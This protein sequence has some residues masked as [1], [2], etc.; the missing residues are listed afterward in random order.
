MQRWHSQINQATCLQE[1]KLLCDTPEEM[2]DLAVLETKWLAL[3]TDAA[4]KNNIRLYLKTHINAK[5]LPLLSAIITLLSMPVHASQQLISQLNEALTKSKSECRTQIN[6]IAAHLFG[7]SSLQHQAIKLCFL[8]EQ[9]NICN[10]ELYKHLD[11]DNDEVDPVKVHYL[12]AQFFIAL[13]ELDPASK[14]TLFADFIKILPLSTTDFYKGLMKLMRFPA[15]L[16]IALAGACID[17]NN[18]KKFTAYFLKHFSHPSDDQIAA[19]EIAKKQLVTIIAHLRYT[20]RPE[21]IAKLLDEIELCAFGFYD[22]VEDASNELIKVNNLPELFALLLRQIIE[23]IFTEIE[24]PKPKD[25]GRSVHGHHQIFYLAQKAG[26]GVSAPTIPDRFSCTDGTEELTQLLIQGMQQRLTPENIIRTIWEKAAPF[27]HYGYGGKLD[28]GYQTGAIQKIFKFFKKIFNDDQFAVTDFFIVN[29]DTDLVSDINWYFVNSLLLKYLIKNQY[30]LAFNDPVEKTFVFNEHTLTL[31]HEKNDHLLD[32]ARITYRY[33][34]E[35]G[36]SCTDYCL[37]TMPEQV[38]G[39]MQKLPD[40]LKRDIENYALNTSENYQSA[41]AYY[42]LLPYSTLSHINHLA[43]KFAKELEKMDHSFL[44]MLNRLSLEKYQHCLVDAKFPIKRI[45]TNLPL[46]QSN[47]FPIEPKKR[48]ILL[49]RIKSVLSKNSELNLATLVLLLNQLTTDEQLDLI[50]S[51]LPKLS[52]ELMNATN[53]S[54]L[55]N[56]L[57]TSAFNQILLNTKELFAVRLV[58]MQFLRDLNDQTVEEENAKNNFSAFLTIQLDKIEPLIVNASDYGFI[59]SNIH[60]SKQDAFILSLENK[61]LQFFPDLNALKAI[62]GA[63]QPDNFAL[64]LELLQNKNS[65]LLAD[66]D[67]FIA[68]LKDVS[69]PQCRKICMANQARITPFLQKIVSFK[70]LV[71]LLDA[72]KMKMLIKQFPALIAEGV[73]NVDDFNVVITLADKNDKEIFYALVKIKLQIF[74][75]SN[76]G[77]DN[78]L[79]ALQPTFLE[80]LLSSVKFTLSLKEFINLWEKCPERNKN[81]FLKAMAS[82]LTALIANYNDLDALLST[83]DSD[84]LE[85]IY[86]EITPKMTEILGKDLSHFTKVLAKI[87]THLYVDFCKITNI[88]QSELLHNK[89]AFTKLMTLV[90]SPKIKLL[91]SA[92]NAKTF[93][94]LFPK[95][96]DF[97]DL[98]LSQKNTELR[99]KLLQAFLPKFVANITD[100]TQ[101]FYAVLNLTPEECTP[102]FT[103]IQNA[104]PSL[105]KDINQLSELLRVT[106]QDQQ[107]ILC[108]GLSQHICGIVLTSIDFNMVLVN[109]DIKLYAQL[110]QDL[111]PALPRLVS[112]P[113]KI[114]ALFKNLPDDKAHHLYFLLCLQGIIQSAKHAETIFSYCNQQQIQS[115]F[116]T[117]SIANVS[118]NQPVSTDQLVS[119]FHECFSLLNNNASWIPIFVRS[120]YSEELQEQ[121]LSPEDE[122]NEIRRHAQQKPNSRTAQALQLLFIKERNHPLTLAD[123]LSTFHNNYLTLRTTKKSQLTFF[124]QDKPLTVANPAD[125][126][127]KID[128]LTKTAPTSTNA[129]AWKLINS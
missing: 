18:K 87:P 57:Q 70:K 61:L 2:T 42:G 8:D 47:I 124:N 9:K 82:R 33:L 94:F 24:K 7:T 93:L 114:A 45:I 88:D 19:M 65:N 105:I 111:T 41:F 90:P 17:H 21:I 40:E 126:K 12:L 60:F 104:L 125:F 120:N 100:C 11:K 25:T 52:I 22:R 51:V 20:E 112:N 69:I 122:W 121:G 78:A 26:L 44:A 34:D 31:I 43:K 53:L 102:L 46:S 106:N 13:H 91:F 63:L 109:A 85:L 113:Q 15:I 127:P 35:N 67:E 84:Q 55:I 74:I 37:A 32:N 115:V 77:L 117:K 29:S 80:P 107:I 103:H 30:L 81:I 39:L 23:E 3:T 64:T 83:L 72:D 71:N 48:E 86:T 96:N 116:F 27:K 99:K 59:V 68:L 108:N 50:L 73:N 14:S 10:N 89:N 62:A 4:Q 119:A 118:S 75:Q 16:L 95:T 101:L 66:D 49:T 58:N 128:E 36:K 97:V 6:S 79:V 98:L 123:K 76:A 56:Q 54:F 129:V 38:S 110:L 92:I 5:N 1:V 28:S